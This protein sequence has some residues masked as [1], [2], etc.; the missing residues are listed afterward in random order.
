MIILASCVL[1]IARTS[2]LLLHPSTIATFFEI[3]VNYL[4]L[5]FSRLSLKM[6]Q[7]QYTP[8]MS[9]MELHSVDAQPHNL[10]TPAH[11]SR[12]FYLT[13]IYNSQEFKETFNPSKIVSMT[14][15]RISTYINK[16]ALEGSHKLQTL[17]AV[18]LI[19]GLESFTLSKLSHPSIWF[20]LQLISSVLGQSLQT[21]PSSTQKLYKHIQKS[22]V[23]YCRS[24]A[25]FRHLEKQ[26]AAYESL[27]RGS[28]LRVGS[29]VHRL[30]MVSKG[31][32]AYYPDNTKVPYVN[33]GGT[34][35][36]GGELVDWSVFRKVLPDI[37]TDLNN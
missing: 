20:L 8:P 23:E 21:S 6:T 34:R 26:S 29:F 11:E 32:A 36:R 7:L 17:L 27:K 30:K 16:Y 1:Y 12:T 31:R 13:I 37:L 25:C 22:V 10:G 19:F 2:S 24:M 9:P 14:A 35:K 5:S 4:L 3:P 28:D 18:P 33:M 15:Q